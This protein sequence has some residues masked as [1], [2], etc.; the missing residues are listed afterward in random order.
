MLLKDECVFV[1][2]DAIA[3]FEVQHGFNGQALTDYVIGAL[4]EKINEED[5]G[6]DP[7]LSLWRVTRMWSGWT[8]GM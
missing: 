7:Y 3:D 4:C 2:E 8:E 1:V 6:G 5:D